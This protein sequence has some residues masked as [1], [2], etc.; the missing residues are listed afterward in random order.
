[1][2]WLLNF[3][4]GFAPR[5]G[6]GWLGLLTGDGR[7]AWAFL[8]L[9]GASGVMTG[10]AAFAMWLVRANPT[11]VLWLGF[12]AHVQLFVCI[13]G[14]M[15]MFVKRDVSGNIKDGSFSIKDKTHVEPDQNEPVEGRDR[16]G[17]AD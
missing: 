3:L 17:G 4:R 2:N 10:F 12:A 6:L 13:T 14:F 15:A 16:T 8:A 1:M 7:R 5:K 9:L 11:Y